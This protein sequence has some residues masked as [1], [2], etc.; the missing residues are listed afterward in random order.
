MKW[1]RAIASLLVAAAVFWALDNHHGLIPPAGKLFNPF[2]GFWQNGTRGDTPPAEIAVPGLKGEVRIVWDSR[3]VPHIFAANDHDLFMAQGYVTALLRLWQMEFQVMYAGGRLA[4]IVGPAG[5]TMDR[6]NRRFGLAWAAERS[7]AKSRED[8][9]TEEA[10]DAYTEGV[11]A[12]IAR[13]ARK[14]FPV[15]YKILDYGPEP[16]TAVKCALLLKYMSYTLSGAYRDPAMTEMRDALGEPVVDALFPYHPPLVDP[17]IPPGT[18]WDFKPLALP[19]PD[20][21]PAVKESAEAAGLRRMDD[22]VSTPWAS[23]GRPGPEIGS[24]NW[25][26]SGKLTHSGFPILCNDMHL[27]LTLPM[28]WYEVQLSAP[29]VNVRGVAFPGAPSV[30]AGYNGKVAWGFTNAGD[31]VLD[32]YT[33]KFQDGTRRAYLYD[34][35]W[36]PTMER[37]E[38]IKVRGAKT[39]VDRVI[40]T[41]RGPVVRLAGE[42]RFPEADVPPDAALRWA[43]HDPSDEFKTLWLLDRAQNYDDYLAALKFWDCPAQNIAYA[44]AAGTI[45]IWHTGKYPL[46][47]HGQGRYILDGSRAA[48]DWQGWVPQEQNPHV[49]NPPRG[50]VSSANQIHADASYPYYLGFDY[51]SY[52]RGARINEILGTAKDITPEDMIRMQADV[53]NIRARAVLPRLLELVRGLEMTAAEKTAF[54]ELGA[55]NFE[56]RAGLKAPSIFEEFW[57]GLNAATWNNKKTGKMT[58]M[59]WPDS[60]VMVDL[61]L[62]KTESDFFDDKTTAPRETLADIAPKAFREAVAK[63]EKRW[64][65]PGDAWRWGKVKGTRIDHLARI[66][67][68]GRPDLETDG[69]NDVINAISRDWAPSWRFVV[70]T[71]R[72]FKAWGTY[73]GGQ[74]GNPGSRY[75]DNFVDDWAVGKPSELVFLDSPDQPHPGIIARTRLGGKR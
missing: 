58:R 14:D 60:Q 15:E 10:I 49:K 38:R 24:N 63:L 16:W 50:F 56:N 47:W 35:N 72:A 45:A 9:R 29:G 12:Y 74:S 28:I 17:V 54:E 57:S 20:L 61:I 68:L 27:G 70:E 22:E 52:E 40:Y 25:A 5:L 64:G 32:W 1:V 31:D 46:R 55:W 4:E 65:P 36:V 66:P 59:V 34:G 7:A 8:A 39:F 42:P 73:P 3:F 2:A 53:L 11:N 44:D 41:H 69:G 23:I 48:D 51:A 18:P 62:N 30:V 13:L 71:G 67:G 33:V 19:K 26:V 43:A 21:T 75:Y 6:F 37:E